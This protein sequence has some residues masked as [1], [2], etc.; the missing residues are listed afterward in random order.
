MLK[1]R[2]ENTNR[3]AMVIKNTSDSIS[4]S[5]FAGTKCGYNALSGHLAT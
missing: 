2:T 3:E 4:C 1:L 5:F